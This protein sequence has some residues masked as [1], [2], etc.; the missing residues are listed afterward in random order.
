MGGAERG[1]GGGDGAPDTA[2]A[3]RGRAVSAAPSPPRAPPPPRAAGT[4]AAPGR[5]RQDLLAS[6]LSRSYFLLPA[7]LNSRDLLLSPLYV[8]TLRCIFT[9]LP[10]SLGTLLFSPFFEDF[11]L[12]YN[13]L[14]S[15][16]RPLQP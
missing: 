1:G 3:R 2:G 4:A 14:S 9:P 6:A 13:D 12:T 10:L 5:R 7:S 15:Y 8:F 16:P 11:F